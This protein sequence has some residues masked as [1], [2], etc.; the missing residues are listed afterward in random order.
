MQQYL[1]WPTFIKLDNAASLDL[2]T[3]LVSALHDEGQFVERDVDTLRLLLNT[4]PAQWSQEG[5]S[6]ISGL[7]D[8]HAAI[9]PIL[10]NRY[11]ESGFC[12]NH[13]RFTM[14]PLL[15]DLMNKLA[16]W[17]DL[18]LK[19]SELVFNRPFFVK[20]E[21]RTERRELFS[22]VLVV[23]AELLY[24]T[25]GELRQ[26][27]T[28]VS[29]MRP[30]E[31]LDMT[32]SADSMDSRIALNLGFA[33]TDTMGAF[34]KA[35][36]YAIQKLSLSLSHLSEGIV[37][38][39]T[40]LAAN[41]LPSE[42]LAATSGLCEL[43]SAEAQKFAGL[44]LPDTQSITVWETR[45]L[46]INFGLY[47]ISQII[48]DITQSAVHSLS[49]KEQRDLTSYLSRDVERTLTAQLSAGGVDIT[50]A[51]DA[52]SALVKYCLHHKIQPSQLIE[53]ELK[54]IHAA[55]TPATLNQL[56]KITSTDVASTPGGAVSKE[57]L[58]ETS[59]TI[60]KGL[61]ALSPFA[62]SLSGLLLCFVC[63]SCGLKTP[64]KSDEA[65]LRP[66]I[67][68]R[69][70][71]PAQIFKNKSA[72]FSKGANKEPLTTPKGATNVQP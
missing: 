64:V 37:V 18:S 36:R 4:K 69:A 62:I 13:I 51:V 68:F 23:M 19:K 49:P 56:I 30:S 58:V 25:V 48:G 11:G 7:I 31:V 43:L 39:L 35:E 52:S 3:S 28:D 70:M 72:G 34:S 8:E 1:D 45:R 6:V 24:D 2:L 27:L 20:R 67:P 71:P 10:T 41:C 60:R 57:R 46:A 33:G 54:K 29:T 42:Q 21:S 55:L 40:D 38:L 9:L 44:S 16:V 65:E 47:T 32:G 66:E 63:L 61:A 12:L 50:T 14:R 22:H 5:R 15:S 59:K 17:A 26:I 53:P